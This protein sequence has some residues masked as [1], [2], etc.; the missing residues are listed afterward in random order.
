MGATGAQGP[1]GP[2]GPAGPGATRLLDAKGRPLGSV[3]GATG[4]GVDVLTSTGHLVSFE[5]DGTID[6]GR[7]VFEGGKCTGDAYLQSSGVSAPSIF[8][9][10]VVYSASLGSLMAPTGAGDDGL[11]RNSPSV[12]AASID[13]SRC[14]DTSEKLSGYR[15]ASTTPDAV[16]LPEYP[17]ATPLA[18]G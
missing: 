16:G 14:T 3:V 15:L 13:A 10:R 2:I 11:V 1:V 12:N 9:R 6:R 4:F 5:W 17:P 8:A 18:F 7:I